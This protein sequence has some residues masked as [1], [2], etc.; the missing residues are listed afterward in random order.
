MP[1]RRRTPSRRLAAATAVVALGV[2]PLMVAV[3]GRPAA[4]AAAGCPWMD[5][6]KTAEQRARELVAAMTLEQE[7]GL[8][9]GRGPLKHYGA[10]D[11]IPGIPELC[12]PH[13]VYNDAGAGVGDEQVG[14]TAFPDPI[15]QA[16]AWD[17]ALTRR[18]GA[19]IGREAWLKGG[20]VQLAPGVKL[21]R[22]AVS[23]RNFEYAGEDPYLTSQFGAAVVQGIQSQHVVANVKHYA[24]NDQESDRETVSVE[25]DERTLQEI[26]LPPF[27]AAVKAGVG[28]VMCAY[29]RVRSVF[30]C[31]HPYLLKTVLRQQFGFQGWVMSDWS[32][33]HSTVAAANAGLDEEHNRSTSVYFTPEALGPAVASGAVPRSRIDDM[34]L[35]KMRMLFRVGVFDHPP[36]AQPDASQAVVSSPERVALAREAA[37]AGTVL[38]KNAGGVLPIRGA[39]K[40]IAVVGA[41]AG[42]VGAQFAYH[43]GGAAKVPLHGTN[44]N[45]VTPLQGITQRAALN[46]DTVVYDSGT[47]ADTAA[48]TAAAADVAVVFA[49][50]GATE[51]FDREDLAL[52]ND[53]CALLGCTAYS[54]ARPADVIRAVAAANPKTVVVA[55]SGG[56][57]AMPWLDEVEGVVETWYPGQ[58]DGHA[59]AAVLFGDVNPSGKLPYTFPRSLADDQIRSAAQ[60]P[61]V[62]V[63]SDDVGP[64]ATYSERLLVGY[65]WYDAKGIA[66]LFPFGYGL[67]Y[68]SFAYADL[69]VRPTASG[70]TATFT[71]TNTGRRAGAEVAQLYVGF[72]KSTGEPPKQ[73]KGFSKVVLAAGQSR[74]V[75]IELPRRAFQ[76]WS[77]SRHAW[78]LTPGTFTVRVGGSS[79]ALPLRGTVTK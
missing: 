44:A 2:A 32:G 41:P 43:G 22:T 73:L 12:V 25:V 55:Q 50:D 1:G 74:Q 19:A 30:A 59:A 26:Y 5:I 23:G 63:P 15:A 60:F 36:A 28:S 57:V 18:V 8:L 79:A 56:P 4:A 75:T 52:D 11:D 45:V 65:R 70:A 29:N 72:P 35:R 9:Y 33:T 51:A 58:E 49:A 42:A 38:L 39:G 37:A 14:T 3:P 10:A 24:L 77:T 62:M 13:L 16:A 27:E 71:V 54:G 64:H 47:R 67:S 76:H 6:G 68:T 78:T 40:R 20:N 69:T 7:I 34:V 31:E 48:A 46:G 66:P 21:A 17:P 53:Q 61:G